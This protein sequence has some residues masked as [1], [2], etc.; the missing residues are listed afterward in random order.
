MADDANGLNNGPADP[1]SGRDTYN[2]ESIL[3]RVGKW[4]KALDQHWQPWR[5]ESINSY[6]I[7][8]G[9]QWTND[10]EDQMMADGKIPVVFNLV[11]PTIDAVAGAEVGSRQQVQY[12]PRQTSNTGVDDVLTQGADWIM[13]ECDGDQEDSEAFRDCLICGIGVTETRPDANLESNIIK[14]RVDPLEMSWDAASRKAN[15]AE[16]RYLRRRKPMSK[17]QFK[18]LW[19]HAAPQGDNDLTSKKPV[20]VDPAI[21]YDGTN[22]EGSVNP[23]EVVVREYQWFDE[24]PRH[25]VADTQTNPAASMIKAMYPNVPQ[26]RGMPMLTPEQHDDLQATMPGART[27]Q[28]KHRA[29]Y[30]VFVAAGQVLEPVSPL[31]FEDF[32]YKAITGK[33]DRNKGTWYGLVRAMKDPQRWHNK[34]FSQILHIMRH[35]AQGGVQYEPG[36]ILDIREFEASWA[37]PAR[38]TPVADGALSNPNGAR[39]QPKPTVAYPEGLDRLM[40]FSGGSIKDVTG[41]NPEMLGL[42]DRNQ[43]GILESQRKQQAFG[44]LAAFFDSKRRY[45]RMQGRLL[46]KLIDLYLPAD[47]LVRVT[48][49]DNDPKY[50]QMALQTDVANYDVIVDEAPAGPNQKI[51]TF[52]VLTQMIPLL[53][54]AGLPADVW[55]DIV[56]YS[57]LP[58]SL[59]EKIG[60]AL[61]DKQKAEQQAAPQQQQM[62]QAHAQAQIQDVAASAQHHSAQANLLNAKAGQVQVE[63]HQGVFAAQA[64]QQP[65]EADQAKIDLDRAKTGKLLSEIVTEMTAPPKEPKE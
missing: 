17:E 45:H 47:K 55:A 39:V 2:G 11:S 3:A 21:R 12:F 30:R 52:Q 32:T 62:E 53:Q 58:A 1:V 24:E 43:P 27:A 29:Y 34:L 63:T 19:P 18:A 15:F 48:G 50:V 35:N 41:V 57:P 9:R 54:Q 7:V 23:D 28:I 25:L 61:L 4:D 13:D 37:D 59:A 49:D 65:S 46:L 51:Q 60:G 42:A 38:N 26:Q 36:A 14:E 44:I 31:E 10:E 6:D 64:A 22:D 56:R 5:T 8:A 20:I 16:A 40:E 33:R